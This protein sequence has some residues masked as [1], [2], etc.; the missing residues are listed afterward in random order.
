MICSEIHPIC[1]FNDLPQVHFSEDQV[2]FFYNR[3][4]GQKSRL[5]QSQA[6]A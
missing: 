1:S 2:F 5:S 4:L 3:F 6:K